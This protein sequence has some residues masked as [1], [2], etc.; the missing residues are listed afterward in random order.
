MYT[1]M[2]QIHTSVWPNEEKLN[3]QYLSKDSPQFYI[4]PEGIL[5]A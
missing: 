1:P 5:I 3:Q 2:F 4:L